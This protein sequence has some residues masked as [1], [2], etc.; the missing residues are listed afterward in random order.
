MAAIDKWH[1]QVKR[2]KSGVRNVSEYGTSKLR[3]DEILEKLLNL[4]S[5]KVYDY[6]RGPGRGDTQGF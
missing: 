3:G 4:K 2:G 5:L 1:M 6:Y